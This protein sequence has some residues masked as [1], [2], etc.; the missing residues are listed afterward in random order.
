MISRN[1]P[2]SDV[3]VAGPDMY[4]LTLARALLQQIK[5]VS[6]HP[7]L[8]TVSAW[9]PAGDYCRHIMPYRIYY[10]LS[11]RCQRRTNR[12]KTPYACTVPRRLQIAS[13]RHA[14]I[15]T[16]PIVHSTG[17]GAA[18]HGWRRSFGFDKDFNNAKFTFVEYLVQSGHIFERN[19]MGDHEC[20]VELSGDDVIPED[21]VPIQMNGS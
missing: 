14:M 17:L 19:P 11:V 3:V 4:P 5:T 6:I 18:R 8:A 1:G 13:R 9:K 16:A 15:F 21:L 10:I 2:H 7:F 20:R 12:E